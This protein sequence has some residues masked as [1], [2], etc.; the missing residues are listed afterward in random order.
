M[1]EETRTSVLSTDLEE[2]DDVSDDNYDERE[3]VHVFD[4]PCAA[5]DLDAVETIPPHKSLTREPGIEA[6]IRQNAICYST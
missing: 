6:G 1:V 4:G 2:V 5:T 3:V